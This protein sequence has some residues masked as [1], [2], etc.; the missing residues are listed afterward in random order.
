MKLTALTSKRALTINAASNT[1][2]LLAQ[3]ALSFFMAPI[4]LRALGDDRNG[5]WCFVESFLAYLMLFDLGVAAALVRFVPRCLV[6][7]DRA[8]LNRIFSACLGFFTAVAAVAALL[9]W[10]F[11][12]LFA[13]HFLNIPPELRGEIRLVFV[14]VVANFAV[15]LPLSVFPAMLDGLNAFTAKSTTRTVFLLLRIPAL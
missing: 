4:V 14:L 1:L 3:L 6:G 2:G 12:S 11:L 5:V 8:G 15:A 13:D 10:L 7:E 9:G